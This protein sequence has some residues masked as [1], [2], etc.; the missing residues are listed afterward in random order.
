MID[1]L[2]ENIIGFYKWFNNKQ[3]LKTREQHH[4]LVSCFLMLVICANLFIIPN[5]FLQPIF[6]LMIIRIL[7]VHIHN[8][9]V[10][11]L[12]CYKF[13]EGQ[14]YPI[15]NIS[16]YKRIFILNL[17]VSIELI[18][19]IRLIFIYYKFNILTVALLILAFIPTFVLFIR[20]IDYRLK[21]YFKC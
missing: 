4:I 7:D 9:N 14:W 20:C 16:S 18:L 11:F 15:Q 2:I 1:K 6:I 12:D 19:Y 21:K 3:I 8:T 17:L 10:A 13:I 5:K